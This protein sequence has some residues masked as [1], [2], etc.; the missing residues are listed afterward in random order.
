MIPT[1]LFVWMLN[2]D[3]SGAVAT[4]P[5]PSMAACEQVLAVANVQP[6]MH[7]RCVPDAELEDVYQGMLYRQCDQHEPLPHGKG[8]LHT[9]KGVWK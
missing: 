7:V 3:G 6:D 1:I 4:Y 8:T 9:C 5:L 2:A